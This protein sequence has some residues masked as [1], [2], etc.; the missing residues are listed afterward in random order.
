MSRKDVIKFLD[1][2]FKIDFRVI[3]GSKTLPNDIK[4][5]FTT[6]KRT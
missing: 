5:I 3:Y 6:N 2:D 1:I 4:K